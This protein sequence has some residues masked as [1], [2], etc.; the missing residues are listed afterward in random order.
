[1]VEKVTPKQFGFRGLMFWKRNGKGVGLRNRWCVK[2]DEYLDI[3]IVKK[4]LEDFHKRLH[5]C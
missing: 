5:T 3:E 1:M 2:V 4:A